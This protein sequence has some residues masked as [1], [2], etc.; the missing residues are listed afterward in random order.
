MVETGPE[1]ANTRRLR[2]QIPRGMATALLTLLIGMA[3][4]AAFV[5]LDLPLPFL[6]GPMA[7]CIVAA[8]AHVPMQGPGK[9]GQAMRTILGVAVGSAITPALIE[10]LPSIA[11]SVALVIPYIAVIGLIGFP[12]FHRICG[13]DRPTA[14]YAA[15][16]GGFQD[17]VIFGEEAGADMRALSLIHATRLLVLV[18]IVPAILDSL[19]GRP[20]NSAP[21]QAAADTPSGELALMVAAALA[22]WQVAARLGMFGASLLGPLLAAAALSLSGLIAPR[23]PATAIIVARL[24]IGGGV[25]VR[26]TGLTLRELRD[27]VGA[28]AV[29]SLFLGLV[30]AL[31]AWASH[32]PGRKPRGRGAARL[33]SRRSGRNGRPGHCRRRRPGPCRRPS[34]RADH[35]GDRLCAR[36]RP[37]DHP[38]LTQDGASSEMKNSVRPRAI[39]SFRRQAQRH[40][41]PPGASGPLRKEGPTGSGPGHPETAHA[42]ASRP[43]GLCHTGHHGRACGP[44]SWPPHVFQ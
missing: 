23:P 44:A 36:H 25:G 34:H 22:G 17:M 31:F 11:A 6:L 10:R 33:H 2:V 21:G 5:A 41:A 9:A 40:P 19:F 16:P 3:G 24:F 38:R 8:L 28:G 43:S 1:S 26:Y 35:A 29:F 13:F 14:W 42:T 32:G 12:F 18:A 20:L 39:H 30:A 27:V 7:A 15:M 4:A 37:A